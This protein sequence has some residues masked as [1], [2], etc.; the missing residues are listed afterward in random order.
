LQYEQGDHDDEDLPDYD[1]DEEEFGDDDYVN[2]YFDAGEG[3]GDDDFGPDDDGGMCWYFRFV[4]L[5]TYL[6]NRWRIALPQYIEYHCIPFETTINI[7][8]SSTRFR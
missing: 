5:L 2:N 6:H 4:C 8:I 7:L 3:D 1:D